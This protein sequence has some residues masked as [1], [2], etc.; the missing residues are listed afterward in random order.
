[1]ICIGD[2]HEGGFNSYTWGSEEQDI[3][4]ESLLYNNDQNNMNDNFFLLHA[5]CGMYVYYKILMLT[6]YSLARFWRKWRQTKIAND[7]WRLSNRLFP[8]EL[9][10]IISWINILQAVQTYFLIIWPNW[11]F[12]HFPIMTIDSCRNISLR[13]R[14]S[15]PA[16]APFF[17]D[18]NKW[19]KIRYHFE[20]KLF[21]IKS[22]LTQV[23]LIISNYLLG[24]S[25][26]GRVQ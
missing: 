19:Q 1:M 14:F 3:P 12:H 18:V 8:S 10:Y 9:S 20:W 24:D 26:F 2:A 6:S 23:I 15:E 25:S 17:R 4:M 22:E 11:T 13:P 7:W 16:A 5:Y 21:C